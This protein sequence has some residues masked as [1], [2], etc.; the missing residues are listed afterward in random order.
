MKQ[1]TWYTVTPGCRVVRLTKK[2][3]CEFTAW[4]AQRAK[5]KG[6]EPEF[7]AFRDGEDYMVVL[8]GSDGTNTEILKEF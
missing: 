5:E 3:F 8:A 6:R 4:C 2:R 1:P 7:V